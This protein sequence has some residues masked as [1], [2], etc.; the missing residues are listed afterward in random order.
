MVGA[1]A[2]FSNMELPVSPT[3]LLELHGSRHGLAEQQQ[4]TGR[5]G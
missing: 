4:Q 3:L 5:L 1:C 2:R